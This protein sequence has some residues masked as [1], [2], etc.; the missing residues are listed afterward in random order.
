MAA[1]AS[2]PAS[3]PSDEDTLNPY[4]RVIRI[5]GSTLEK[6]DDDKL[7]PVFGFGDQST[8]GN[9]VFPFYPDSRPCVGFEEVVRRYNEITPHVQLSGPTNFAPIIREAIN[10]SVSRGREVKTRLHTVITR[11]SDSNDRMMLCDNCLCMCANR[12]SIKF[13]NHHTQCTAH[14]AHTA[15][16][17]Q[18]TE[19]DFRSTRSW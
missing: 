14:T 10:I 13:K 2:A 11:Q 8:T 18:R 6:F 12:K 7:I 1:P 3:A 4:Q 5:V 19:A 9:R 16:S 17:A 15:H